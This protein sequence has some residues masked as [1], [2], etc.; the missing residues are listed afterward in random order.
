MPRTM[1]PRRILI[2]IAA[3]TVAAVAFGATGALGQGESPTDNLSFKRLFTSVNCALSGDDCPVPKP[4]TG[5]TPTPP[6]TG[7]KLPPRGKTDVGVFEYTV[8]GRQTTKWN[9]DETR[10]S[11]PNCSVHV[12]GSGE[13]TITLGSADAGRA[14][15]TSDKGQLFVTPNPAATALATVDRT[16]KVKSTTDCPPVADGGAKPTKPDCG[17]PISARVDLPLMTKELERRGTPI[18]VTRVLD[19]K[20]LPQP[21]F[22]NCPFYGFKDDPFKG[23]G[24]KFALDRVQEVQLRAAIAACKK[25]AR[26]CKAR[27]LTLRSRDNTYRSDP[28]PGGKAETTI[29]W[30]VVLTPTTREVSR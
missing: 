19:Y 4:G 13:Q 3:L 5:P 23:F 1:N 7:G 2:S 6:G 11:F 17:K 22:K 12:T 28:L 16:G 24:L 26:A 9:L 25:S 27:A 10:P 14:E 30:T 18:G 21:D 20:T 8:T 29:D 15:F